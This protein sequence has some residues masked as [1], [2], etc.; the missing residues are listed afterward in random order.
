MT[1]H[2]KNLSDSDLAL[3]ALKKGDKAPAFTLK[4]HLGEETTLQSFLDKG[5]VVLTW[6]RGGW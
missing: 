5:P 1:Q 3:K 2:L 4:N 6:Y